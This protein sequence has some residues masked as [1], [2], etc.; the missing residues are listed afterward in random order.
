MT[1]SIRGNEPI[2]DNT[3][4]TKM[5]NSKTLNNGKDIDSASNQKTAAKYT[6]PETSGTGNKQSDISQA[7]I[8]QATKTLNK[9]LSEELNRDLLAS[10]SKN[11][12]P[13]QAKKK[14]S[15]LENSLNDDLSPRVQELRRR[16]KVVI[17]M[18]DELIKSEQTLHI[19]QE[20]LNSMSKFFAASEFDLVRFEQDETQKHILQENTATLKN[21]L[22]DTRQQISAQAAQIDILVSGKRANHDLLEL[23][24][25]EL[26][27]SIEGAKSTGAK[28]EI[29]TTQEEKLKNRVSELLESLEVKTNENNSLQKEAAVHASNLTRLND[30]V[31]KQNKQNEQFEKIR[32]NLVDE[33]DKV[34]G[35]SIKLQKNIVSL[36]NSNNGLS[37]KLDTVQLELKSTLEDFEIKTGYHT[38]EISALKS[39]NN[40]LEQQ[41]LTAEKREEIAELEN[42]GLKSQIG[43]ETAKRI[44][45]EKR[46]IEQAEKISDMERA[47]EQSQI[48][49]DALK[50]CYLLAKSELEQQKVEPLRPSRKNIGETPPMQHAKKLELS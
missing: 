29:K 10:R 6:S 8:D 32:S 37:G 39:T 13:D 9:E 28:L 44:D 31:S 5:G 41:I 36:T 50:S 46:C 4:A 40:E 30:Q 43:I 25:K 49:H 19:M 11:R 14:K 15:V 2:V 33:R 42:A 1:N 35:D 12:A 17:G 22:Q 21:Q 16:Q 48:N 24:R 45:Y 20:T 23:A 18:G 27:H 26:I 3:N 47:L 38:N 34:L 7:R